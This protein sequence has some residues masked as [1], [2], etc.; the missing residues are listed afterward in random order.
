MSVVLRYACKQSIKDDKIFQRVA[1]LL[2]VEKIVENPPFWRPF[3]NLKCALKEWSKKMVPYFFNSA[4]PNYESKPVKSILARI[5]SGKTQQ[6]L[7]CL[8]YCFTYYV[9][10]PLE[11]HERTIKADMNW[12][13]YS[14][15]AF[16]PME[17]CIYSILDYR[18]WKY[19]TYGQ[20]TLFHINGE[21]LAILFKMFD[22]FVIT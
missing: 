2:M 14:Y 10:L 13:L 22:V 1:Y 4:G 16:V 6:T 15:T 19:A 9:L 18:S 21:I 12:N 17:Q 7:L 11:K 8:A 5:S 20:R 3:W